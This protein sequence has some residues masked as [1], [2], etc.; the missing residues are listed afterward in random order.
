MIFE[1]GLG[2]TLETYEKWWGGDLERPLIS[3]VLTGLESDREPSKYEYEGQ[4]N[5]GNIEI[6]PEEIVDSFDYRL[7]QMEFLGDSYPFFN[8]DFSGPGIVA[9][10][11]GADVGVSTGN[12][13][14]SPKEDL[15]IEEIH[16]EY[17]EDNFWLNRMKAVM[18]EAK[19]R[20]GKSVVIGMPDLG[21]VMDVLATF[22]GTENLLIDLY[23]SPDEVKRLVND[24]KVLWQRYFDEFA[25]Y[26]TD[27][28][29][30]DWGGI[31]SKSS[32]YMMQSDFCFM[33]SPDMFREFALEELTDTAAFLDRASY[34]LDGVGQIAF[35][36]DL[37]K[38]AKM[39]V[40]QW[41]PG[42]G[43]YATQDWFDLYCQVL[44][45]GAHLQ[46]MYDDD[47]LSAMSKLI[48]HYG[49]GKNITRT[50]L[51]RNVSER[52]HV[53]GLLSRFGVS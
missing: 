44:D 6:T 14:F 17:I 50:F 15:P 32:T 26:L 18:S 42:D 47:D 51:Y 5:F 10:F 31:L 21:G 19:Q 8:C 7:S 48:D 1:K 38:T 35:I 9:A 52:G 34:H 11:L 49:T 36:E 24:I 40:I 4:K 23:E 27:G 43:Q 16:L 39:D 30:A 2:R 13:W 45:L 29:H 28:F 25:P 12:I 33:L 46:I 41:V 53:Q 3:A 20:W 22:R 37:I